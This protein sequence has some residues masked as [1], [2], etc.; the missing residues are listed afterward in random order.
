MPKITQSCL[1]IQKY[2]VTRKAKG[3]VKLYDL[4]KVILSPIAF[5]ENYFI[6]PGF[7]VKCNTKDSHSMGFITWQKWE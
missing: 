1:V 5:A 3:L 7:K 2:D 6:G 4:L